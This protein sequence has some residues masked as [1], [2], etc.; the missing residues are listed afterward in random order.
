MTKDWCCCRD[1]VDETEVV[2]SAGKPNG[3]ELIFMARDAAADKLKSSTLMTRIKD[4]F[5]R[6]RKPKHNPQASLFECT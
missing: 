2:S 5:S 1:Q 3:V 4:H 6:D